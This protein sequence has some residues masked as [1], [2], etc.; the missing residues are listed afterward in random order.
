[1]SVFDT[2]R[3][4]ASGMTAQRFRMDVAAGNLPAQD[5]FMWRAPR[6]DPGQKGR[7]PARSST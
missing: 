7:G 5:G 6:G 1:M 2:M 4:A 3:I